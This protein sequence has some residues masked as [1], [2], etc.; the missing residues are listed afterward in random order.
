MG[1]LSGIGLVTGV[2]IWATVTLKMG[3][4]SGYRTPG[5]ECN[6]HIPQAKPQ[7]VMNRVT[8]TAEGAISDIG[9]LRHV[10]SNSRE[11]SSF[12]FTLFDYGTDIDRVNS[13][14][15]LLL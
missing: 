4:D 11:G 5:E 10:I 14:K 8:V 3:T 13:I 9:G 6:Y 15:I 12:V 7:E 1:Y 2:S